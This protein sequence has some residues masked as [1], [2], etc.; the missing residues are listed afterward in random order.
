MET[1]KTIV[2]WIL[3]LGLAAMFITSAIPK[4]TGDP[5]MTGLFEQIGVGQWFRIFTGLVELL[6]AVALLIPRVTWL[7]SLALAATM[8]GAVIT[9][10]FVVPSPAG[11]AATLLV[12]SLVLFFLTAPPQLRPRQRRQAA[13]ARA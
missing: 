10:L 8:A 5:M 3:R 9:N 12:C 4:L 13:A 2:A 1:I 11:T 7:G 6:A